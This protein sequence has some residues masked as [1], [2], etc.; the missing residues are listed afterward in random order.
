MKITTVAFPPQK[1]FFPFNQDFEDKNYP[2]KTFTGKLSL[3][4]GGKTFETP[5]N[6][7]GWTCSILHFHSIHLPQASARLQT[8]LRVES[9]AQE[10]KLE[11]ASGW[12]GPLEHTDLYMF[13]R[14][15]VATKTTQIP[16]IFFNQILSNESSWKS[17]WKRGLISIGKFLYVQVF[18]VPMLTILVVICA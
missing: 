15:A 18:N 14:T 9:R 8:G 11:E 7:W 10:E 2:A 6:R 4:R 13:S 16:G 12:R 3:K 1:L 17:W 5:L